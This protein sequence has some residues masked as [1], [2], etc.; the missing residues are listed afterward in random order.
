MEN[1][2]DL[3]WELALVAG[4]IVATLVAALVIPNLLN[5]M[6]RGKQKRTMSHLRKIGSAIEEYHADYKSYPVG[7]STTLSGIQTELARSHIYNLP[8]QDCWGGEF[9]YNSDGKTYTVISSG[10]DQKLDR[11]T[12]RG[13]IEQ[14]NNDI[15][16][17]N[18]SFV[19]FPW[20]GC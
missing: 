18:G 19:S 1:K 6:N 15:V 2:K 9:L 12:V 8:L 17:S 13:M 10:K 16:F 3:T 5:A 11:R 14:F 4:T 20:G 7:S